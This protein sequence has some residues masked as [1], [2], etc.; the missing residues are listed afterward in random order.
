[1]YQ[2]KAIS[3]N[4]SLYP[5]DWNI[6]RTVAQPEGMSVSQAVRSIIREWKRMKDE[7]R[8]S[9]HSDSPQVDLCSK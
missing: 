6:V 5:H 4:I 3:K 7:V 1:M 9:E 8:V 2:E